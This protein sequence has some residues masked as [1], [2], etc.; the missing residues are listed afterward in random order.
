M[1]TLQ[2]HMA[3]LTAK[4]PKLESGGNITLPAKNV[5]RM[6]ESAYMAGMAEGQEREKTAAQLRD[7]KQRTGNS[8][9]W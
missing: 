3:A 4:N 9:P 5:L 8:W 7:F 1:M 6:V 2:Q